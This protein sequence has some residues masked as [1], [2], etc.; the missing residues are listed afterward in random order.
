MVTR[1]TKYTNL[2]QICSVFWLLGYLLHD[3]M[4][5]K[6]LNNLMILPLP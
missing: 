2:K 4:I 5:Y 3:I 1:Y 6:V